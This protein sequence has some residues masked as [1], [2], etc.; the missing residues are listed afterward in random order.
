MGS[1]SGPPAPDYESA[2]REQAAASKDLTAQQ[3][4]ANR[5]NQTTPW[6]SSSWGTE[7]AIDPG[8]GLPITKWTQTQSLD[9]KLQGALD[10]QLALQQ[11]R[12]DLAGSFMGRVAND[13]GSQPFNWDKI[14]AQT[15][16]G[17]AI[18]PNIFG[19][20]TT[21]AQTGVQQQQFDT[22]APQKTSTG[23]EQISATGQDTSGLA[24]TTQ[25]T[26][27]ANFS[28]DRRRIED[29]LFQRMQPEHDRQ[30]AALQA[31]LVNQGLT[32]GS[33]AY[34]QQLQQLGDQQARERFNAVQQG[35]QEQQGLQNMLMGQQQQAFGQTQAGQAAKNQA[36]QQLFQQYQGVGQF[37]L[38][39]GQQ[40]FQQ[41]LAAQQ[42]QNAAK[43][44]AF[45]Q[46]LSSGQF[47]NQG[48]QQ[49]FAQLLGANAQNFGQMMGASNY[50]NQLRQ[51]AIAEEAQRRNMSLNEMN[52]LLT[53]QQVQSPNMP[54]FNSASKADTP[55]LLKAAGMT[56]QAQQD[57]ANASAQGS[58]GMMSGLMGLGSTAMMM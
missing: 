30:S 51:Q 7:Q 28:A 22:S 2:A 27:E 40:G 10:Q 29:T 58:Q 57:A 15:P 47:R 17:R 12:S 16:M 26:N 45:Q 38:G 35:G 43:Q 8:T 34:N 13:M 1:K 44:A 20:G 4:W 25:T 53:G 49:E 50:Q 9:P 31:Q 33:E 6:G 18:N 21:G 46:S 48:M 3:N 23:R 52:A 56:G 11:G 5:P 39:A 32:P 36:L 54:G 19:T 42:A 14:N 55:E 37:G 24:N 41:N